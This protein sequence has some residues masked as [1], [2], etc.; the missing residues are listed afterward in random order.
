MTRKA[1]YALLV[2]VF[3]VIAVLAASVVVATGHRGSAA[4][5]T[6]AT[7]REDSGPAPDGSGTSGAPGGGTGS[8]RAGSGVTTD[9]SPTPSHGAAQAA[10]AST[11][12][13]TGSWSAALSGPEPDAPHGLPGQTL[14][15]VLRVSVGGDGVRVRFSNAFGDRPLR[16]TQATVALAG[17][18]D[19]AAARGGSMR[20]LTFHGGTGVTVPAHG[21]V[22]S[23]PVRLSVPDGAELLVSSYSPTASGAVSYHPWGR[24][25]SYAARGKHTADS[26]GRAFTTRTPFWRYVSE[27]DVF[28]SRTAGAVVVLGDSITDGIT[29]TAGANDRWTDDLADRLLATS[30]RRLRLGVLNE[31]ISGD[32]VLRD[33]PGGLRPSALHRFDRDVL[34]HPGAHTLVVELGINDI[35]RT[36]RQPS[37]DAIVAGLRELVR[38]AH[39][40]GLRVVGGTLSPF[41]GHIGYSA[42]TEAVR[43]RVN[44]R[45]RA[46]HVYDAVVDWDA[47]LRDPHHPLRLRKQYDSGDHLHPSDAGYQAMADA[48]RLD[49]LLASRSYYN[50]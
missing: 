15:N 30:D 26:G 5:R 28:S 38:R 39:A 46:G 6:A 36:P 37:A 47:A 44:E 41:Q 25:I 32:R 17:G 10:P 14:R 22:V 49:Q 3:T 45:I 23:D 16:L 42:R 7:R 13:W 12:E 48:L 50:A 9:P 4:E 31:G 8:T 20:E 1:G 27:V 35:I 40:A 43:E 2:G 18:P 24:E 33:D 11:G 21:Q 29:S 19:T 34:G